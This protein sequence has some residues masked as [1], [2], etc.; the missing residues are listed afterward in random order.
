MLGFAEA[1]S[2][3]IDRVRER[4]VGGTDDARAAKQAP[5]GVERVSLAAAVGRVLAEVVI[6]PADI[7]AADTSAMDGYAVATRSLSGGAPLEL[8]VT[9]ECRTGH[10]S[11]P[12]LAGTC[13]RIFTGAEVPSGADAVVM[14][15][16]VERIAT[17]ARFSAPPRVG[18]NIR[19]RGEDLKAG[20]AALESG[21]RLTPFHL[22]LLAALDRAEV[23]VG[24][25][26]RVV[27]V[28]T[29]DELRA[30]GT[31]GAPGLP[32][33]N[34]YALAAL[35]EW[36]GANVTRAPIAPDDQPAIERALA[37]AAAQADVILTI[38]GVS[39]GDHDLVRP[40]LAALGAESHFYKVRMKPGKP[41]AL[42][43]LGA[44][45]VLGLPGN[46][47]SAQVTFALFGVPLLRVLQGDSA[48][49]PALRTARTTRELRQKPGRLGFYRARVQGALVEPLANQSSGAS[50][51]MAWANCLVLVPEDVEFV[52]VGAEVEVLAHAD[53]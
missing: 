3:L 16:S 10:A 26:P 47:A 24:R 35:G 9:S 6:A 38:G 5:L 21:V 17:R 43:R 33:S 18:E 40:A 31:P 2:L 13:S 20:T 14:Q 4:F 42:S 41:L 45:W 22:G 49:I 19:R 44:C 48:P 32:E 37:E 39:V 53:L 36:A 11:P 12:L 29:G 51:T 46:P 27:I 50:T 28:A 25:R 1:R 30:P 7:P 52:P 8:E 34:G 23:A 15:E